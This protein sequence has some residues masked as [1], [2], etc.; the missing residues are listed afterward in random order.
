MVGAVL[1]AE[2]P[3]FPVLRLEL[4]VDSDQR[5]AMLNGKLVGRGSEEAARS[6]LLGAA[7]EVAGGRPNGAIRAVLGL[8][9]EPA[10]VGVVRADGSLSVV[11]DE[12]PAAAAPGRRR[13]LLLLA[14]AVVVAAGCGGVGAVAVAVHPWTRAA[15]AVPV[16]AS[17]TPAAVQLPVMAPVGWSAVA[18]WSSPLPAGA[19]TIGVVA[20]QGSVFTA[21][22][23]GNAVVALDAGTGGVRWSTA[24]DGA[25]TGGPALVRTAAGASQLLAWTGDEVLALDPVS[26]AKLSTW[27]LDSDLAQVAAVAGGIVVSGQGQHVRVPDGSALV[28]RV[29][30]AGG[31]VAGVTTSGS[32][33]VT[34]A[35]TAWLVDSAVVAGEG[36]TLSAPNGLTWAGAVGMAGDT[37]VGAFT[38]S[39]SSDVVLRGF[40]IGTW[41]PLWT[42]AGVP[43]GQFIGNGSTP[44]M[45]S[46]QG[47]WGIYG[48]TA[49]DLRSGTIHA[50]PSDWATAAVGD[51]LALGSTGGQVVSVTNAG[52]VSAAPTSASNAGQVSVA[53]AAVTD[54]G[55]VLIV[56]ADGSNQS[57]YAV[58]RKPGPAATPSATA[59]P[60][61]SA[62]KATPAPT[63][64]VRA[65]KQ[66]STKTAAAAGPR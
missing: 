45:T 50:L 64:S 55:L 63:A 26:G 11:A 46:P 38:S 65:K 12:D 6:A 1:D 56:G 39:T 9:F 14:A 29:V 59:S 43:G 44:L 52:V 8:G 61:A 51:T 33:V 3:V 40:D 49:I 42:T 20:A 57:L 62:A 16:A 22:A 24:A 58:R 21:S 35:D 23:D 54:D 13:K 10:E 66:P 25:L 47:R 27:S 17:V 31:V 48:S 2:V 37:L 34:G 30:P 36:A 19:S 7:A 5:V 32:L 28:T 18:T 41:A 60:S 15:A 4:W 53:P